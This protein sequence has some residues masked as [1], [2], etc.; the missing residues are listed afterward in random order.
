MGFDYFFSDDED[1][2]CHAD[3]EYAYKYCIGAVLECTPHHSLTWKFSFETFN[4]TMYVS[5]Y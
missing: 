3:H 2:A 1:I 4:N 5:M